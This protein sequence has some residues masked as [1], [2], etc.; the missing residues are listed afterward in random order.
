MTRF[1]QGLM[2]VVGSAAATT[3][4]LSSALAWGPHHCKLAFPMIVGCALGSYENLAGGMFAASTA[5]FAGW[6][7][8]SAVQSQ[9]TADEK[10]AAADRVEIDR[11]LQEDIEYIAG[12]LGT[13]WRILADLQE[14]KDSEIIT[15]RL[16]GVIYGIEQITNNISVMRSMVP[17][18]NWERRRRYDQLLDE[19]EN[20][21][22][23]K[24]TT[25]FDLHEAWYKAMDVGN[26]LTMLRPETQRYFEGLW[27]RSH[28]AWTLGYAIA[29]H[30]GAENKYYEIDDVPRSP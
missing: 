23:F 1:Q 6:L 13:I 22:L 10:R 12:G 5:L 14:E 27:E 3:A 9:I 16:G 4:A 7:A 17:A 21:S 24:S 29:V 18:L 15:Q 30:A 25:D 2:I 28:K 26:Y 20:L 8:W 19:L 11:I